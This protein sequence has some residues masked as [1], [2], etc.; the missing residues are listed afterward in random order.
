MLTCGHVGTVLGA[1]ERIAGEGRPV[2]VWVTETRPDLEGARLATWELAQHSIE[3]VTL[4]DSAVAYLLGNEAIDAVLMGAE[5][6]AANGDSANVIGSRAAAELA[7][8]AGRD[9]P[10]PVM[11]AAPVATVD[12]ATADGAALPKELR[13]PRDLATFQTGFRVDR[14]SAL[15]PA[16]D[17]VPADRIGALVTEVGAI[18]PSD[19]DALAAAVAERD[20]RRPALPTPWA[21]TAAAETPSPEG[22]PRGN[23]NPVDDDD[24]DAS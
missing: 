19:A 1:I 9:G 17:V 4:P 12:L 24:E 8:V 7:A 21:P 22:T 11:V 6:I 5:W 3:H 20:A 13:P 14:L 10:V 2:K 23:A 15:N 16:I 18:D